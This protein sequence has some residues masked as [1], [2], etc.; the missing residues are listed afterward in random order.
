MEQ[1]KLTEPKFSHF[2][3]YC[4]NRGGRVQNTGFKG[5]E[6][7]WPAYC[8]PSIFY[9]ERQ[10]EFLMIQ[11]NVSY[12]LNGSKG[13][14]WEGYGPL[15]YS[16][17]QDRGRYLE[18]RNF[19]GMARDPMEEFIYCPIKM[20]DRKPIWE[21]VGLEDARC[22]VWND[23]T[24]AIGVRRDD[25]PTG[26]GRM[27]LCELN[28]QYEEVS[29]VKLKA[30]G[31][32][33]QY[34]IKNWMP[35]TDQPY[36]FVH[37]AANP[38]ILVK[39]DPETGEVVEELQK[40][41][42]KKY[43]EGFDMPRGS[44]HCIPWG[45]EG[46]HI[47]IVHTCQMYYLGNR[48]KFARYLHAFIEYDKEWN[49]IK[50]SPLFSFDDL[51]VE[52]CTGMTTKGDEVYISFALQDNCSYILQ[53]DIHTI[54]HFMDEW[55]YDIPVTYTIWDETPNQNHLFGYAL[56]LFKHKDMAG[57]YTWFSKAV[58]LYPYTYDERFMT[59][60]AIAEL[61]H[62]DNTEIG[63]WMDCI[64]HDPTRP[65][66][67]CAAAMYYFCRGGYMEAWYW[68]TKAMEKMVSKRPSIWYSVDDI[69][70]CYRN[71]LSQTKHYDEV[72]ASLKAVK[73]F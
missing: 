10:D 46:H 62:R 50:V 18:T 42:E 41:S 53:T 34:C 9:D 6:P 52:F 20:K 1:I 73:A 35:V 68:I 27:E 26:V 64:E 71:I 67:Y 70:L 31:G 3:A 15:R 11:R 23:K 69:R 37:Q 28:D 63:L 45:N 8:N 58:D 72:D 61:G 40:P 2:V 48:R 5:W 14:L 57:A 22:V 59:A 49:I 33:N 25:N 24:Y 39:S 29:S 12:V 30:P 17:P 21:F 66:A 13:N 56:D 44:S 55:F 47:C 16:I 43:F 65:E 51:F 19:I 54:N 7:K 36:W 32:N 4:L 38:T 60:R